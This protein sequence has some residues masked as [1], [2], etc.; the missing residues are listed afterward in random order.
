[1]FMWH[2]QIV[3]NHTEVFT[4]DD[5]DD[6]RVAMWIWRTLQYAYKHS[7]PNLREIQVNMYKHEVRD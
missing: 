7:D 5:T 6:D 1:M 4:M 3:V 2:I